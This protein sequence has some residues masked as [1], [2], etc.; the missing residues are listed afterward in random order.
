LQLGSQRHTVARLEGLPLLRRNSAS[1]KAPQEGSADAKNKEPSVYTILQRVSVVIGILALAP[2]TRIWVRPW[3]IR[4]PFVMISV[5]L[6]A[7]TTYDLLPRWS[8][9]RPVAVGA[10]MILAIAAALPPKLYSVKDQPPPDTAGRATIASPRDGQ[11]QTLT[12]REASG[13]TDGFIASGT[14]EVPRGYRAVLVSRA[15]SGAGYWLLSDGIIGDCVDDGAAHQWTASRVDPTWAGMEANKPITIGVIVLQKN[16]ADQAQ[17]DKAKGEPL[18]L[19]QPAATVL[20]LASRVQQH[21][22]SG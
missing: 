7:A 3:W 20:V 15:D 14:C 1:R 11:A 12:V 21:D 6:F 4:V 2:L 17:I 10:L 9:R 22:P 16:L 5:M 13:Y 8:R 19:P 18:A